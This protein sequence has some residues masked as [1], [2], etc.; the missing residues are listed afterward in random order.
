MRWKLSLLG[1]A[2]MLMV[3]S[4]FALADASVSYV[5]PS[6]ANG[7]WGTSASVTINVTANQSI[8][9]N[10]SSYIQW[11][12]QT[13]AS[14][15]FSVITAQTVNTTGG[16]WTYLTFTLTDGIHRFQ[17]NMSTNQTAGAGFNYSNGLFRFVFVDT[18]IPNITVSEPQAS[19]EYVEK[20]AVS[21]IDLNFSAW[22]LTAGVSQCFYNLNG[23]TANS[24]VT[25][26]TN[27]TITPAQGANT[28]TIYVNDSAGHVNST[29]ITFNFRNL[30]TG[31]GNSGGGGGGGF[32][33]T[34]S[35]SASVFRPFVAARS[36]LSAPITGAP[37]LRVHKVEM[38]VVEQRSN[39]DVT[40]EK[41]GFPP[42]GAPN[43]PGKVHQYFDVTTSL[44]ASDYLNGK[45]EFH[46]MKS[47]LAENGVNA[48][49][50]VLY[51]LEGSV[52]KA[53]PTVRSMDEIDRINYRA[54]V[55]GFSPFAISTLAPGQST[56]TTLGT[57]GV[58]DVTQQTQEVQDAAET[59]VK[60]S[61]TLSVPAWV[62]A[63]ILLIVGFVLWKVVL[64][65]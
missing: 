32:S 63:M 43:A 20:P 59:N 58:I 51:H 17:A 24:T 11:W 4:S 42:A 28:I 47:W 8:V 46:V 61:D 62:L 7:T 48:D 27:T 56:G 31:N 3:F 65:K 52:W 40:V 44:G 57:P 37:D 45:I 50:V 13:N 53:Q 16:N 1:I 49:Q 10:A 21:T 33:G 15:N 19:Y 54:T 35:T 2:L 39:V 29:T 9:A 25:S 64:K 41:I 34:S 5:D 38:F 22:D 30:A 23:A 36:T 14:S 12:N 55:S 18:V 26:C 6:P 60:L